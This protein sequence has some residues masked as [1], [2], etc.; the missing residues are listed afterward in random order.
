MFFPSK[1]YQ[2]SPCHLSYHFSEGRKCS[3]GHQNF[4]QYINQPLSP[5]KVHHHL[6][7]SGMKAVVKQKHP[8]LSSK[9]HKAWLDFAYAHRHWTIE[10]WKK[11]VWS[12]KTKINCLGLDG[13]KWVWKKAGEGS[14]IHRLVAGTVKF[15]GGSLMM[16]VCMT[17]QGVGF[18][19]K[20]DGRMDGDLY[21]SDFEG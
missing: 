20:I 14:V 8:L 11:V 2:H 4:V 10:D 12:D 1:V 18:A 5:N 15:E 16:W 3:Q 21:P 19:I 17:W 6:T 9:H 13:C 7:K